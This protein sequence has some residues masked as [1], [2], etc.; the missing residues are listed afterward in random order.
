M[1]SVGMGAT[2]SGENLKDSISEEQLRK[3]RIAEQIHALRV[4]QERNKHY[5]KRLVETEEKLAI[6][7]HYMYLTKRLT[8]DD[9]VMRDE[10]SYDY[11]EKM[12]SALIYDLEGQ[13]A[14]KSPGTEDERATQALE[15][16][17]FLA[18]HEKVEG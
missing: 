14:E 12:V 3:C 17:E 10:G 8:R 2:L 15:A 4:L 5:Y 16:R 13:I 11:T 1:N 6:H 7:E 9:R 18:K